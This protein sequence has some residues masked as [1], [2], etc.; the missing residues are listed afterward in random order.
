[1]PEGS[2]LRRRLVLEGPAGNDWWAIP[3]SHVN[4][5]LRIGN[6]D[7]RRSSDA[8]M[9]TRMMR[10]AVGHCQ[11]LSLKGDWGYFFFLVLGFSVARTGM[12]SGTSDIPLES[13]EKVTQKVS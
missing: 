4:G 13:M 3:L 12:G 1:M 6:L 8:M 11:P 10:S 7:S 2:I 9:M 5:V